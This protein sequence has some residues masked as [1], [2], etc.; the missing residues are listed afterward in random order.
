MRNNDNLMAGNICASCCLAQERQNRLVYP[1]G[2]FVVQE[3]S[4]N[5]DT[6][7]ICQK[8]K[9]QDTMTQQFI[10]KQRNIDLEFLIGI[11]V[12]TNQNRPKCES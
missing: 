11:N 3:T 2:R 10:V 6:K 5:H 1:R 12:L 9:T 8:Y 4:T 7:E